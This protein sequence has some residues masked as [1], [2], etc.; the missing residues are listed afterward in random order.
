V[1]IKYI[2][3]EGFLNDMKRD[4][5]DKTILDKF[6][7]DF[8]KVTERHAKYMVVGGFIAI[9]HGRS[10]G[11]ED[12]D[13]IIER[14]PEDKFTALHNDLVKA[15]FECMQSENPDVIYEYL[16]NNDGVRYI[17]KEI[18]VP[19]MELKFAKD[20]LDEYGLKTRTKLPDTKLDVYFANID[21]TIAFKEELLGTDKDMEDARHLRILYA[22][23][24]NEEEIKDIKKK[25][26][27]LRL[28]K[29]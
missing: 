4:V 19:E 13:M 21:V 17:R 26:R 1:R 27:V 7:L 18:F 9:T 5:E 25:I 2:K 8:V 3:K 24:I 14:L 29:R 22:N 15:G 16:K 20:I 23:N 10:R 28:G 6:L 11:T 12:I